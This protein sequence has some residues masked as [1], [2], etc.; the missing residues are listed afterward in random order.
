MNETRTP[1]STRR[2]AITRLAAGA[3]AVTFPLLAT[4]VQAHTD[5]LHAPKAGPVVKPKT[6]PWSP[7]STPPRSTSSASIINGSTI[8]YMD[9]MSG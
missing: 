8:T 5:K 1:S 4:R 6:A 3:A 9:G 7:T 2:A